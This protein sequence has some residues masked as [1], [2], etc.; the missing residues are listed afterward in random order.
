MIGPS[1]NIS[2][3]TVSDWSIGRIC[4]RFLCLIGPS[5][6]AAGEGGAQRGSQATAGG[7][8]VDTFGHIAGGGGAPRGAHRAAAQPQGAERIGV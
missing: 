6:A 5:F 7:A 4:P 1:W 3:L 2:T 8:R